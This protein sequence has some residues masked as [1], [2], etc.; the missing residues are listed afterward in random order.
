MKIKIIFVTF[1]FGCCG[2]GHQFLNLT[3]IDSAKN[4]FEL[5][6]C[7]GVV[8]SIQLYEITEVNDDSEPNLFSCYNARSDKSNRILRLC[9]VWSIRNKKS[10]FTGMDTWFRI[11]VPEIPDGFIQ[12]L[13][14]PPEHFMLRKEQPYE[15][16]VFY[17]SGVTPARSRWVAE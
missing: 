6:D 5:K 2:C 17:S 9:R 15:I 12:D 1:L 14:K 4:T 7:L 3:K 11:T 16:L 10:F 8:T 13:P